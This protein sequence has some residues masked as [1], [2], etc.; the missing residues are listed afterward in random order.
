MRSL[1]MIAM[2]IIFGYSWK[3]PGEPYGDHNFEIRI[4]SKGLV[5]QAWVGM[6]WG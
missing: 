2:P 6:K 3:A 5:C 1:E 4:G